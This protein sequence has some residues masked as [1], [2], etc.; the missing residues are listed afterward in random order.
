MDDTIEETGVAIQNVLCRIERRLVEL[1]D[2]VILSSQTSNTSADRLIDLYFRE[3]DPLTKRKKPERRTVD[4]L[5][6]VQNSGN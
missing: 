1:T 2:A 4:R 3:L 6:K 5:K